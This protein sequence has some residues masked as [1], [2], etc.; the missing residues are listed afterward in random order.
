MKLNNKILMIVA[1]LS[2]GSTGCKDYLDEISVSTTTSDTYYNTAA[3]YNDLVRSCYPLWRTITQERDLILQGTDIFTSAQW[4]DGS[5]IQNAENAYDA[6]LNA[7]MLS[8]Q[9]LWTLLYQ[10]IGRCNTAVTR[11]ADVTGINEDELQVRLAEA[12]FLRAYAYFHLVQQWGDVPMPLTETVTASKKA[13]RV[14]S[15]TVY[16]QII[17]DLEEAEDALPPIASDYGRATKGAAQF[18]L[19]RV[20]LTRGWNFN[21]SLGGSNADFKS[22]LDYADKVIAAYPLADKYSDLFPQHSKNPLLQGNP[23]QNDQNPEIVFAVQYS[24]NILTNENPGLNTVGNNAHSIFGGQVE[25]VPG[26]I[27]RTSDYNRH[28]EKQVVTP[29]AYRMFDPRLDSRYAWNFVQVQYALKDQNGFH[30]SKTDNSIVIDFKKG[31]TII[32]FRPWNDPALPSEKGVDVGGVKHYAVYNVPDYGE[33][34]VPTGFNDRFI[35]PMMWKFWQPNIEYGDA[36]GTTDQILFRSAE[37]YLIAAEAIVKG[38]TGGTLGGAEVYYNKVLDRALGAN[39]GAEPYM[40]KKPG[41]VTSLDS[42]H[43]RA[44]A[45]TI[46][47]DM[48]L[49]ERARELMGENMRWYDLKRTG[50]LIERAKAMNPWTMLRGEL[51]EHHLLRPI[52]QGEI[53]LSSPSIGQ[54][55]DYR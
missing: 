21:Q 4:N 8:L 50:K 5:S 39:A 17:T 9:S 23:A 31:D 32:L 2:L 27:G 15:A 22:A 54:N 10:E 44:T 45:A 48:I 19:A 7:N 25:T 52:P 11:A 37:A 40:A 46:N 36:F 43:Y 34:G 38:A 47:I 30:P 33:P 6:T 14:A 18:L 16:T 12:K 28:Q 49:D 29:A 26:N 55:K 53:D 24:E 20:Y 35:H 13:E 42:V 3:G 1:G 51:D 41:E